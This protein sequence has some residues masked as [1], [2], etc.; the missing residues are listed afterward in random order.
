MTG[1]SPL[2]VVSRNHSGTGAARASRRDGFIPGIIYG[3]GITPKNIQI[4]VPHLLRHL[5]QPGALTKIYE[6]ELEGQKY[7]TLLRDIQFHPVT[8]APLHVDL[9]QISDDSRIQLEVPVH[10]LNE[11]KCPGLKKAGTLNII[12]HR[13]KVF[14]TP[15]NIPSSIDV[16]LGKADIG[17]SVHFDTIALPEGITFTQDHGHATIAVI[18]PPRV[19]GKQAAAAAA[20]SE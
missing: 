1:V 10:F 3:K 15:K 5:K 12:Q 20:E 7:R 13:L 8:D 19:S 11:E 18:V 16:D 14:C 2:E 9:M 6:F 4:D 17:F